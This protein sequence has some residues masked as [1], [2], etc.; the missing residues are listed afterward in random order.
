[1]IG[2]L[3]AEFEDVEPAAGVSGLAAASGDK[4][5]GGT[6]AGV[7]DW[8]ITLMYGDRAARRQGASRQ[9]ARAAISAP[10]FHGFCAAVTDPVTAFSTL[11]GIFRY[12][13][14]I[15]FPIR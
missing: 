1:M 6:G 4:A 2:R 10:L 3:M 8:L 14:P 12:M 7:S 11:P 9:L 5:S 13:W 15:V